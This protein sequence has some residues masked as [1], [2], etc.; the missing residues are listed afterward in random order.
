MFKCYRCKC[1]SQ[2]HVLCDS[3]LDDLSILESKKNNIAYNKRRYIKKCKL[4][5]KERLI[6]YLSLIIMYEKI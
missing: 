3:C 6:S 4:C 5:G 2:R 1:Q